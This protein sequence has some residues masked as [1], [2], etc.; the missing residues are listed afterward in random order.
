[1]A[2]LALNNAKVITIEISAFYINYG[3]HPNLF[4]TLKKLLQAV[5]IL[6]DV[7]YLKQIYKEILKNIKYNQ[8]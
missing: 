7:K 6:E 5:T 2:Q 4:N 8:K 3:R 1:M